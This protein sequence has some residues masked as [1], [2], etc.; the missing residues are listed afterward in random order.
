MIPL[1]ANRDTTINVVVKQCFKICLRARGI[2]VNWPQRIIYS[3]IYFVIPL[4][5][6][7]HLNFILSFFKVYQSRYSV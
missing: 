5:I 1:D 4:G 6:S 3:Y 2:Q 7:H